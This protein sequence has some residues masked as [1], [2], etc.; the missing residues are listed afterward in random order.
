[1]N[2]F[3]YS[4]FNK[5]LDR[6]TDV[7]LQIVKLLNCQKYLELGVYDGL[8]I[9]TIKKYCNYCVGVDIEDKRKY[10]NYEF[11]LND[12][13]NFF[14]DNVEKYDVIFIDADHNVESVKKDFINSLEILNEFG[15]IFI[16]DTDPIIEQYKKPGY[17]GDSYKIL[18]WIDKTYSDLN[19]ITLP[20]TEAG[21]TI[22]N[23]KNDRRVNKF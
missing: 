15:I 1:M 16:H 5:P 2:N 6:H 10:F 8:N 3:A 11:K 20:I 12:T 22:I 19:M 7:I 17:C 9:S 23:R 21:L 13:D 14:N 18:N 4:W